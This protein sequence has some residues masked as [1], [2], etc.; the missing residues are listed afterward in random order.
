MSALTDETGAALLDSTSNRLTPRA[1]ITRALKKSGVNGVGQAPQAA[2]LND[3]LDDLNDMFAQWQRRRWLVTDLVEVVFSPTGKTSY[4]IGPAITCDIIMARP[5]IISDAFLRLNPLAQFPVDYRL[6]II[7]SRE[8]YNEIA[9]KNQPGMMNGVYYD[10]AFPYG[11][12]FVWPLPTANG[13]TEVHLFFKSQE[14]FSFGLDDNISLPP[15]YGEAILYNLAARLR[16]AYQLPPDPTVVALAVSSLATIRKANTQV[17]TLDMPSNLPGVRL[18]GGAM[19]FTTAGG[20]NNGSGAFRL[21]IS[22]LD[23]SDTLL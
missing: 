21:D 2:D 3:A 22:K 8:D 13:S 20:S 5:D 7:P 18:H 6:D 19:G 17:P 1:L 14:Y 23:G 11:N 9:L 4:S 16:P 15:E 12:I 10:A